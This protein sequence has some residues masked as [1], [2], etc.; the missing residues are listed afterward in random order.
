[1]AVEIGDRWLSTAGL[2]IS[3]IMHVIGTGCGQGGSRGVKGVAHRNVNRVQSV[4]WGPGWVSLS[5]EF[6]LLFGQDRIE[7][8]GD[9]PVHG[10]RAWGDEN[11]RTTGGRELSPSRR[12][13]IGGLSRA[14]ANG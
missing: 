7:S 4:D 6:T 13:F 5:R 2:D 10:F 12:A 8:Q 11:G 3:R 9:S 1:M 14:V